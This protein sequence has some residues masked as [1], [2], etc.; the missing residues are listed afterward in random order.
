MCSHTEEQEVQ[1]GLDLKMCVVRLEACVS[2]ERRKA[3]GE[4]PGGGG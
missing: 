3:G 2:L 1:R 4:G